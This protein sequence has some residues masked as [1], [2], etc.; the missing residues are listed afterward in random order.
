[1]EIIEYL[2][3]WIS[4]D[5][6]DI[7]EKTPLHYAYE[8]GNDKIV[9]FLIEKG[10]NQNIEDIISFYFSFLSNYNHIPSY[11]KEHK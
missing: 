1:M 8:H 10:A 6:Q 7:N 5:V 9:E 4:V 2:V 3:N 11:Y